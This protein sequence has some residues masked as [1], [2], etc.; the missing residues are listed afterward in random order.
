MQSLLKSGA[1]NK[2]DQIPPAAVLW[3]DKDRQWDTVVPLLKGT[4]PHLLTLGD[5][6]PDAKT[7]P[8]IWLKCMIA[9]TLPEADWPE[10]T[11][12]ILYLPG[13][14]RMELRAIESCPTEL[15][16]LAELQYRGTF[17]SQKNGRD[18]T[19]YAFLKSSE[20]G[21]GLDVAQ[22]EKTLEA[23]R[24][25]FRH[26][27]ETPVEALTGKRLEAQDFNLLL[28]VDPVRDLLRWLDDPES[29]R[30]QWVSDEWEAYSAICKT[31]FSF[32]PSTDGALTGAEKLAHRQGPW[33]KVWQRYTESPQLYPKLPELLRRTALPNDLFADKSAWPQHNETQEDELRHSLGKLQEFAPHD[34]RAKVLELDQ[35]NAERRK[36]V[37]ARLGQAPLVAALEHLAIVAKGTQQMIAGTTPDELSAMYQK[38]GWLVDDA[39]LK[40]LSSVSR[41]DDVKAVQTAIH[42]LYKPWLEESAFRLQ[43]AVAKFGYPG[44]AA[45]EGAQSGDLGACRT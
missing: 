31:E 29:T 45:Y 18:W 12:P 11:V 24:R 43:E 4:F 21:I 25:A 41:A 16:P 40:A 39:A 5:Y 15:Q 32:S 6:A 23:L 26:V 9:R 7:G 10:S 42:S 17:W 20:G 30:K 27:L 22:D 38:T 2:H 44:I 19:L 13:V 35:Q 37:W 34:A 1:Y 36:S 14:S 28:T 8:A 33:A 3:T